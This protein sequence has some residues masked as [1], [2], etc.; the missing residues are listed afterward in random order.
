MTQMLELKTDCK[1]QQDEITPADV[2][3][4]WRET[5]A[6]RTRHITRVTEFG[7]MRGGGGLLIRPAAYTPTSPYQT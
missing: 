6:N 5:E 2:C 4:A 7:H 3:K 1:Q